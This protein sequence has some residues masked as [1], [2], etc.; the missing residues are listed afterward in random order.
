MTKTVV[1]LLIGVSPAMVAAAGQR[2]VPS[3]AGNGPTRPAA[4]EVARVNGTPI[5]SDRLDAALAA[6]IPM[7]SF[8]GNV[9]AEKRAALRRQ[10]LQS[11]VDDEL[12]YQ[13]GIRVGVK[14]S[15][16]DMKAAWTD[17]AKR[18][19]GSRGFEDALRRSGASAEAART[20]IRRMLTI[21]R[22]VD[23]EVTETCS[24][25][26]AEVA[27]FF[28][29]N[30]DRFVE[31]EQLHLQA[32]T[33]GVDPSSPPA[34]WAEAKA[35]AEQALQALKASTPFGE[36]ALEYSTDQSKT[37]G[38][39]LG[40]MHRGSLT[41]RFEQIAKELP[42]GHHSDVVESLYGYHIIRVSEIRPAQPKTF[43]EV[44]AN[45]QRDLTATR[46][47]ERKDAWVA[48][49]RARADVVVAERP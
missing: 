33:V 45:L 35:R 28:A 5:M 18:Y 20:E 12:E 42:V 44:S 4:H 26:R 29:A 37:A 11:L 49:L 30:P 16:A 24:V 19:G 34:Q 23:R 1:A 17:A 6:L 22:T 8:H 14:V 43:D 21:K 9:R 32:V 27:Q 2:P 40:F 7:E 13:H 36:V 41:E 47:A 46:C 48:E 15:D 31:P 25:S 39:D 38:G 10:A 3:R